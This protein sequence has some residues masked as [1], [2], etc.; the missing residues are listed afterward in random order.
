MLCAMTRAPDVMPAGYSI[1]TNVLILAV[2]TN[3]RG[4]V[5]SSSIHL[6]NIVAAYWFARIAMAFFQYCNDYC[7]VA[8]NGQW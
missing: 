8:A 7:H 2:A 3:A 5:G 1:I 6:I 4:Y